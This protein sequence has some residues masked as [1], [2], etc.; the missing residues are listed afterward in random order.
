[1]VAH[2][3]GVETHVGL[4]VCLDCSID[5]SDDLLFSLL[6]AVGDLYDGSV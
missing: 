1:M 2:N 4:V 6:L 5:F 3:G